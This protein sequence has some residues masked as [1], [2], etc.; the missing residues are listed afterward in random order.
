MTTT[1]HRKKG[2]GFHQ[3]Q[4]GPNLWAHRAVRGITTSDKKML[5]VRRVQ[6]QADSRIGLCTYEGEASRRIYSRMMSRFNVGTTDACT[7]PYLQLLTH[8][9]CRWF[10]LPIILKLTRE[11]RPDTFIKKQQLGSHS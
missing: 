9:F 6:Q 10:P 3:C 7:G 4:T 8:F 2:G 1:I 11:N 5:W